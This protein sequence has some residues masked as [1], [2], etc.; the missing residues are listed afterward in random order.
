VRPTST[1]EHV[2]V[3]TPAGAVRGSWRDGSAAFLGIPFAEPPFGDLRFAAPEPRVSWSHLRDA[4]TYAPTPQR[5]AL[6]A[7]TTIPEP[8]IPGED[9]LTVNVF[10]PR[11]RPSAAGDDPLPVMVFIHGGGYIAGSPASP[12][13][14]GAAFNRDGVV[15]VTVSYRLGFEGFGWLPDAPANRGVLDWLLALE[16]VR[17]SIGSFGGDPRRVTI[18]GQSAGGGA[19]MTLLT[20]PRAR[21]LF[22]A[23]VSFSGVPADIPLEAACHTTA[24]M[25]ERLGVTAD[26]A[27][28]AGLAEADLIAAQRIGIGS[29]EPRTAED[30]IATLRRVVAGVP[31]GPVLDELHPWTVEE[32]LQAGLG[33]QVPLMVGATRQELAGATVSHRAL[34]DD[35]DACTMLGDL[36]L[37]EETARRFVAAMPG[38]HPA[39]VLGQYLSDVVFRRRVVEWLDL[40]RGAAPT[41]AYDFAWHSAVSGLAEHCLDLPFLFDLLEDTTVARVTGLPVPHMLADRLHGAFVRFIRD[42]DPG[43]PVFDDTTRSVQIFDTEPYVVADGYESARSLVP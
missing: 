38:A 31:F 29:S 10:T 11:P 9:I 22:S 43:W 34:F 13:Y 37:A 33:R 27:G 36:G 26:R 1:T 32:A 17:D 2:T 40:R 25:A 15:T 35:S 16:W 6:S 3:E 42:R 18:A 30:L 12:W 14:D 28:F 23:A 20:M 4:V 24:S 8:S 39:E 19:V 21:G 41:W 5:E 7:V